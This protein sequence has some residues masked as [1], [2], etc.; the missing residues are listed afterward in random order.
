MLSG[1]RLTSAIAPS[2]V[3]GGNVNQTVAVI[4][5]LE[6]GVSNQF[7]LPHL[8]SA[9]TQHRIHSEKVNVARANFSLEDIRYMPLALPPETEQQRIV[10][11]IDRRLSLVYGIEAE[12]DANLKRAERLRQSMLAAAFDGRFVGVS[13][14]KQ[15][16]MPVCVAK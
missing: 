7:V 9:P 10:A 5:L 8:L 15:S 2:T 4:R 12:T 6:I 11:E 14:I 16:S 13:D 1:T 3:E